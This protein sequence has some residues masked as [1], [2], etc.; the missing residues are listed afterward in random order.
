[1]GE[2]AKK[3]HDPC[4]SFE[5]PQ[6]F[7]LVWFFC[8]LAGGIALTLGLAQLDRGMYDS[9]GEWIDYWQYR[10]NRNAF[11]RVPSENIDP[12]ALGSYSTA[13]FRAKEAAE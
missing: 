13:A 4:G 5:A 6:K 3:P 8:I 9:N 10:E 2:N 11:T 12:R 7:A 1:M